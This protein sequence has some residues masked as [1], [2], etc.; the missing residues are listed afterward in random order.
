[1]GGTGI[2]AQLAQV[3]ELE[4]KLAEEYRAVRLLRATIAGEAS[5]RGECVRELGK[6]ARERI[7]ADFN[8]DDPNTPP[9]RSQKLIT[10]AT[11][12][13]AM[14]APS[15]PEARNLHREAQALIEQAAEQQAESSA[16]HQGS[17][18]DDGGAPG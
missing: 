15:T 2:N 10:A 14:P 18:R 1:V 6:Q 3:R 11:L 8:V 4:A 7:N 9:R 17:A 13:R 12:L 5:A 16:H